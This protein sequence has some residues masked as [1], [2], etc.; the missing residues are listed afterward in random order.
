LTGT[1]YLK[2]KTRNLFF[3]FIEKDFPHLYRDFLTV[4]KTGGANKEYKNSL[5]KMVNELRDRYSLSS[6][7][8]NIMKEKLSQ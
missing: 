7:Y 4:Y 6:S 8:S 5:Y 3:N 1:L 2:G